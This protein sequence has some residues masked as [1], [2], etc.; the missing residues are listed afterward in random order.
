MYTDIADRI[1]KKITALAPF[2]MMIKIIA[3]L[4][5][6]KVLAL[7]LSVLPK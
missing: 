2:T 6:K 3:L 1:Q 5:R 4:L 7:A